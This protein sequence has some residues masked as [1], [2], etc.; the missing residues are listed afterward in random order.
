M[1]NSGPYLYTMCALIVVLGVRAQ[2][3][4]IPPATKQ[5]LIS[6]FSSRAYEQIM[7]MTTN[8]TNEMANRYDFCIRNM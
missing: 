5:Y 6:Q 3:N 2:L 8:L 7:A 4:D 1:G